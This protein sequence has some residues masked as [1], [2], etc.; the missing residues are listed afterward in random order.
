MFFEKIFL[1]NANNGRKKLSEW[2]KSEKE[3]KIEEMPE[4]PGRS[5]E[6]VFFDIQNGK[7]Y[8]FS[9]ISAYTLYIIY[10]EVISYI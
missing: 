9:K 1:K 2:S 4:S 6:V 8:P 3:M 5:C 7:P 10:R